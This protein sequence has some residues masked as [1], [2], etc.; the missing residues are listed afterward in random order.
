MKTAAARLGA[1]L[2]ALAAG[3]GLGAMVPPLQSPDEHSHLLRASLIARGEILLKQD[4][5]LGSGGMVDR[6][7]LAYMH[8]YLS[9]ITKS[10]Q[11]P[12]PPAWR[13]EVERLRWTAQH[14][15]Y[16]LAG[17]NYYLPLVYAPHAAGMLAGHAL[18][19]T[20]HETYRL[21]RLACLLSC[22][23]LLA[24]AWRVMRPPLLAVALLLLPMTLFQLVSPTLD[25]LTTCLAV[26][27]LSLAC[28]GMMRSGPWSP[29]R[30]WALATTILLL[31]TTRIQLLPLLA[32][33]FVVAWTRRSSRDALLGGAALLLSM[34]WLAYALATTV[35]PRVQRAHGT[36][37]L[38]VHYAGAPL[39]FL[40]VVWAS[41]TDAELSR[42][43]THSFVGVLGW[44]DTWLPLP[45]Y[46][47]LWTGLALCALASV[48]SANLREAVPARGLLALAAAGSALLVFLALLLTWTPHP[49]RVVEGVQGRYFIVPA[50]M[51]AYA[52]GAWPSARRQHWMQSLLVA[53]FAAVSLWALVTTLLSRYH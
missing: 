22:L 15:F 10:A 21:V 39:D 34:G 53:A 31:A 42:F 19:L 32:V 47:A 25:G 52:F 37:Q 38:L 12:L 30:S 2:L 36:T 17:T 16:P 11:T 48:A 44:L 46:P 51:L 5:A 33:P 1:W 23:V 20:I 45:A 29:A 8:G 28:T 4:R 24:A 26:L 50:V 9:T 13:A 6:A 40:S 43:Y 27:A 49:A 7:L 14:T 18:Q 41:V 35:D 3:I